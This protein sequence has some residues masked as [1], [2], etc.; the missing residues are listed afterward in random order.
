MLY[1]INIVS[2]FYEPMNIEAQCPGVATQDIWN[3]GAPRD[4]EIVLD[5]SWQCPRS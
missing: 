1:K 2:L 5:T 4:C 3:L